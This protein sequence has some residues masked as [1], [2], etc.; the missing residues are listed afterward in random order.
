MVFQLFYCSFLNNYRAI[1]AV[2]TLPIIPVI[3]CPVTQT[4]KNGH[5]CCRTV[6]EIMLKVH[7]TSIR[8]NSQSHEKQKH[9]Q[10]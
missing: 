10:L 6:T 2:Q 4:R 9:G 3:D 1:T 8:Q 7:N 5:A